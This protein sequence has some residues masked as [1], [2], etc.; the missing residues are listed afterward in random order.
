[1]G[2]APLINFMIVLFVVPGF[3]LALVACF[4]AFLLLLAFGP[5]VIRSLGRAT[6]SVRAAPAV[7]APS[8]SIAPSALASV[9][10]PAQ[11]LELW[12]RFPLDGSSPKQLYGITPPLRRQE[13]TC[14]FDAQG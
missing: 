5:D 7:P 6:L 11:R 2:T 13:T 3:T 8:R 12:S 4:A 1:M 10:K 9:A 14:P